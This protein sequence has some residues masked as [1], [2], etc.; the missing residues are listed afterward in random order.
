[1]GSSW[2]A[3]ALVAPAMSAALASGEPSTGATAPLAVAFA[4]RKP[5]GS[6]LIALALVP[7]AM[8]AALASG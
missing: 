2:I 6:S 5:F 4:A 1:L 7:P 8:S 3:L